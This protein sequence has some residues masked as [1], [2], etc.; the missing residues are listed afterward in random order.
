[1]RPKVAED[2]RKVYMADNKGLASQQLQEVINKYEK[3]APQLA[4]WLESDFEEGLNFFDEPKAY[5]KKLRTSNSLENMHKQIN[6]RTQVCGLFPNEQ[7]ALR[8]I[9]SV[10][11]DISEDWETGRRYLKEEDNF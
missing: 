1:M 7:S 4:K 10:L 5:W 9:S 8:L 3:S 11:M 6:R 2:L